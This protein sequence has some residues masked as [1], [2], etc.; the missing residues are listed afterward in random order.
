MAPDAPTRVNDRRTDPPTRRDSQAR[1]QREFP[2]ELRDRYLPYD[3]AGEGSEGTVWHVR[4]LADDRDAAVKIAHPGQ[5][6]DRDTLEHLATRE[7]SRHVP[8]IHEFGVIQAG[9]TP[10]AWVAMEYLPTTLDLHLARAQ[11]GGKRRADGAHNEEMVRELTDLL[12][13]WQTRIDRNPLDLK[14][15]NILVRDG[16]GGRSQFVVADFGGITK[17][18]V[19]QSF[20][21]VQITALYMAP[22]QIV[23]Q[24]HRATPWWTLGLVLYQVFTGRPLYVLDDDARITD[25]AW[26]RRLIIHNELDLGAVTDSRQN[27]LLQGLLTKDPDDRWT[28]DQVRRWLRGDSPDVIRPSAPFAT[29]AARHANRPITFRGEPHHEAE[30]LAAAMAQHSEEAARWLMADGGPRLAAWLRDDLEDTSYDSG[31]LLTLRKGGDRPVRAGVAALA[32]VAAFAPTASPQ[33][34]GRRVDAEGIARIAQGGESAAFVDELLAASVPRIAARFHCRHDECTDGRCQ[35]L[36]TVADQL[37]DTLDAVGAEARGLRH[38]GGGGDGTLAPYET[39]LVYGLAMAL[40]VDPRSRKRALTPLAGLP[41]ALAPLAAKAPVVLLVVLAHLAALCHRMTALLHRRREDAGFLRRWA[42][43]HRRAAAADP[44]TVQGRATLVAATALLPRVL[45]ADA[46]G[47]DHEVTLTEWWSQVWRPL[48][49]RCGAGFV[50]FVLLWLLIWAG[51]VYRFVK[52]I[53][54]GWMA[55][56]PAEAL[57]APLGAAADTAVATQAGLCAVALVGS[58]AFAVAPRRNSL[59]LLLLAAALAA[60][61]GYA[62][63]DLP[64]LDLLRVS[65]GFAERLRHFEGGWRSWNGVV[66]LVAIPVLSLVGAFFAHWMF[67]RAHSEERRQAHERQA[68]AQRRRERAGLPRHPYQNPSRWRPGSA[69]GRDRLLFALASLFTLVTVLWAAVETRVTLSGEHPTLASWGTGQ[70]GASYQSQY[71][72][73]CALACVVAAVLNPLWARRVFKVLVVLVV[74]VGLTPPPVEPA[75]A[76]SMPVLHDFFVETAADWGHAAFWAALLLALPLSVYAGSF[77]VQRTRRSG[78]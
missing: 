57:V 51:A 64:P 68:R 31:Q 15:A 63:P 46:L 11:S 61:L 36:L 35:V 19:S 38:R 5:T 13:F 71:A 2:Q 58:V 9:P 23:N 72:V 17:F 4:R 22:E 67:G 21:D 6:M 69:G 3:M 10:C 37:P 77:A 25:E 30:S 43:L 18:T 24:N 74:A 32:F 49:W 14:P 7:F 62:R 40:I 52:D 39:N 73:A 56:Q 42:D 50:L 16:R 53:G 60:Y 12:D 33:Y 44:G 78:R 45:R 66:S 59:R 34:R 76:A 28:A 55:V 29:A 75:E 1:A 41:G 20:R 70:Q 8:R 48:A 65:G 47:Q 26:T 54:L 27:L